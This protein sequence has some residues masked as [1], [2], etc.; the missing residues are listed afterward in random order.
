MQLFQ[1]VVWE[2]KERE[3]YVW[4]ECPTSSSPRGLME[5]RKLLLGFYPLFP[6]ICDT[7]LFLRGKNKNKRWIKYSRVFSKIQPIK[8]WLGLL[9]AFINGCHQGL[10]LGS[11]N[12]VIWKSTLIWI[13]KLLTSSLSLCDWFIVWTWTVDAWLAMDALRVLNLVGLQTKSKRRK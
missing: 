12:I 4:K 1:I 5:G 6:N 7:S 2:E 8:E 3:K 10:S 9:D 13:S 11:W